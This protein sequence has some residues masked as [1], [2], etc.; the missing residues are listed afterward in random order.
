ME[1]SDPNTKA[2]SL[3]RY[4][5]PSAETRKVNHRLVGTVFISEL[6]LLETN[7]VMLIHPDTRAIDCSPT[8]DQV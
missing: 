4:L 5:L 8:D 2:S 3:T 6:I 7:Q 1:G